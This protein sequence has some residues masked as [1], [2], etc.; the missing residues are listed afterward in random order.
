MFGQCSGEQFEIMHVASQNRFGA[1][2]GH[3]DEV[4]VD[5]V[6]GTRACQQVADFGS[7]IEG[8]NDHGLKESGEACLSGTIAPHLGHH[9]VGRR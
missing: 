4:G 6:A 7:V 1:A 5:N 8:N 2:D 9:G 3:H